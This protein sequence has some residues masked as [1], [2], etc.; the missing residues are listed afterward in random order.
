VLS[1]GVT[2]GAPLL[3]AF[4]ALLN[5]TEPS[6]DAPPQVHRERCR[7]RKLP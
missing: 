4:D 3:P 2:A 7:H 1:E 5:A 6:N